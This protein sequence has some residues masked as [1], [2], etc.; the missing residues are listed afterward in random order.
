MAKKISTKKNLTSRYQKK[1]LL[2]TRLPTT[3][4]EYYPAGNNLSC[5]H[6]KLFFAKET[7][8]PYTT[9]TKNMS[10][11]ICPVCKNKHPLRANPRHKRFYKKRFPAKRI[12]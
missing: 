9:T 8:I 5:P 12:E 7:C 11:Y 6:C 3:A 2:L 10:Y 4:K 1:S